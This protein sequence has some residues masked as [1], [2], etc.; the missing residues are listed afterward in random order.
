MRTLK[1]KPRKRKYTPSEVAAMFGV[2]AMKIIRWIKSGELRAMNGAS[3]GRNLRP[4]YLIDADD[5]A[6][7][8]IRRVVTGTAPRARQ[9]R[10]RQDSDVTE[11]Y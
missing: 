11:Y 1:E 10:R 4:R 3:P 5:L 8:E 2:D 9:R 6:D 7:F